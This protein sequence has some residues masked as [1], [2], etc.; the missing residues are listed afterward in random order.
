MNIKYPI[1]IPEIVRPSPDE[2]RV[3]WTTPSDVKTKGLLKVR[4]LA[5]RDLMVPV[6][7]LRVDQ[8]LLFQCCPR[9]SRNYRT[10]NTRNKSYACPHSNEE[11][12][13][14]TVVSDSNMILLMF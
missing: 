3:T 13:F 14:V 1:G 4:V 5:P 6:L 12:K 10:A 7:P 8:R 9:C 11:R 2:S